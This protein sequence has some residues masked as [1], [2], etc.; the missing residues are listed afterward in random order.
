MLC[1]HQAPGGPWRPPPPVLWSSPRSG[2]SD[3]Q[4]AGFAPPGGQRPRGPPGRR[5]SSLQLARR[6]AITRARRPS[7]VGGRG[8]V[9]LNIGPPLGKDLPHKG[10]QGP[11]EPHLADQGGRNDDQGQP[12]GGQQEVV[13]SGLSLK[14]AAWSGAV[15]C[16][17]GSPASKRWRTRGKPSGPKRWRAGVARH[18]ICM[19]W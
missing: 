9:V 15:D 11:A 19:P 16:P 12:E 4:S 6:T 2:G 1:G 8:E 3:G 17:E 10:L 13:Q 7:P 18:S 14:T 5:G